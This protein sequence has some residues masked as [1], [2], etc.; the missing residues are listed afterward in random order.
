MKKH[1]IVLCIAAAVSFIFALSLCISSLTAPVFAYESKL[2]IVLDA[3]HGG[4]DGGVTGRK[5]GKKESEINLAIVMQLKLELEDSGF[6][7][8]LTRKTDGGLYD[9][10]TDG[11]K[12]R[13]M[14]KRKEII[15]NADPELVVSVHQNFYSSTS[16]RGG[17]VFFEQGNE[18]GERLAK[19]IQ[20][21]LNAVYEKEGVKSRE[22]KTGEYYM[23]SCCK[24]PSVI[25]ECGFLSNVKDEELLVKKS[26]QEKIT[27]AIYAG[28]L[29][30]FAENG[31]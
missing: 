6:E 19:S 10:A 22:V 17:Q 26:G 31:A 24:C 20:N 14:K 21:G 27:K 4:I 16:V 30:Y 3:G 11:F 12:R 28:I 18:R 7:V 1:V 8:V 9:V 15:E 29:G 2:T 23:V 25:V 13:D 5:T